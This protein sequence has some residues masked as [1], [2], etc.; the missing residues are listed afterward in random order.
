[1]S[2]SACGCGAVRMRVRVRGDGDPPAPPLARVQRVQACALRCELM[3]FSRS[4]RTCSGSSSRRGEF[5]DA[6][7]EM[8]SSGMRVAD[9]DNDERSGV[10]SAAAARVLVG[11]GLI[12]LQKWAGWRG[13]DRGVPRHPLD[14]K[15][16][17]CRWISICATRPSL[18]ALAALTPRTRSPGPQGECVERFRGV[19]WHK[20]KFFNIPHRCWL[21]SLSLLLPRAYL[22]TCST[23]STAAQSFAR[24]R[25]PSTRTHQA[26][27]TTQ[28]RPKCP[29]AWQSYRAPQHLQ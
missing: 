5:W 8:V 20:V 28:N 19:T 23:A 18:G 22:P 27:Q 13:G 25:S 21:S 15:R 4:Q 26:P 14:P 12:C 29:A 7:W 6:L 1:M 3:I 24:I 9:D 11:T 2:G 16:A 17:K 10:G